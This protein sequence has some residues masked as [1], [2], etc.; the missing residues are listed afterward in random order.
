MQVIFEQFLVELIAVWQKLSQ[1]LLMLHNCAKLNPQV[2][3]FKITRTKKMKESGVGFSIA[4]F[5]C[6]K[7]GV[8]PRPCFSGKVSVELLVH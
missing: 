2:D 6:Y 1:G 5:F 8:T 4:A 7:N 3:K